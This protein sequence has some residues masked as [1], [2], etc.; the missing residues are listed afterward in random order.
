MQTVL[1]VIHIIIALTLIIIILLQRSEGG[2]L[3]GLGGGGGGGL[4]SRRSAGNLL[5]RTTATLG[6]CFM[7]TSIVLA[8]MSREGIEDKGSILDKTVIESSESAKDADMKNKQ[9]PAEPSAPL[10]E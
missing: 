7:L 5:T 1:L 4:I 2:A 10:S 6:T 3:S 9:L 8:L